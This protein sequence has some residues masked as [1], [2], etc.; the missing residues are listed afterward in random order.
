MERAY[1]RRQG[2]AFV[3][4]FVATDAA[5]AFTRLE[6]DHGSHCL[7]G[8][9]AFVKR[10]KIDGRPGGNFEIR[11]AV[12]FH[13]NGSEYFPPRRSETGADLGAVD[14]WC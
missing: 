10:L 8:V 5:F 12:A 1:L 6:I 7:D 13:G 9:S 4:V 11:A 14:V 3:T 2:R